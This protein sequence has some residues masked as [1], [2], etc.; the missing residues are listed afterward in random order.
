MGL[1]ITATTSIVGG[2]PGSECV[3]VDRPGCFL[4]DDVR[5]PRLC[6]AV[7]QAAVG[8]V[9]PLL[10]RAVSRM[11]AALGRPD[12]AH[13]DAAADIF[14]VIGPVAVPPPA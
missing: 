3:G 5:Q 4:Y 1:S 12:C 8:L 9:V 11:G 14:R 6:P 2:T 7:V 10:A 13:R